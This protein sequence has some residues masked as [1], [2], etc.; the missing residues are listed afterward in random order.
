LRKPQSAQNFA[1]LRNALLALITPDSGTME[2][3]F[4]RYT[5]SLS[6]ALNSS[7]PKSGIIFS[8][9]K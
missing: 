6:T 5:L 2:Q 1:L 7:T 4:E 8:P 9:T 3:T